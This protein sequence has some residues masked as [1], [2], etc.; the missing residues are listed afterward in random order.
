MWKN[1]A[2]ELGVLRTGLKGHLG[3]VKVG[4]QMPKIN[5]SSYDLGRGKDRKYALF[6]TYCIF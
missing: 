4:E 3:A 6:E 1:R 5:I 2:G